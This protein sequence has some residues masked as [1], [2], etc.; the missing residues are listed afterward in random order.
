[1]NYHIIISGGV[2]ISKEPKPDTKNPEYWEYAGQSDTY[3]RDSKYRKA[4]KEWHSKLIPVENA[5]YKRIIFGGKKWLI[6]DVGKNEIPI[7]SNYTEGMQVTAEIK[8]GK[9]T[10][11]KLI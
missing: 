4:L 3:F 10:I 5:V 7:I 8:D 1:M 6:I 9:A 11:T 2:F